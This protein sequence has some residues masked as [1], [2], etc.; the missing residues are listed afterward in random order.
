VRAGFPESSGVGIERPAADPIPFASPDSSLAVKTEQHSPSTPVQPTCRTKDESGFVVTFVSTTKYPL[1]AIEAEVDGTGEGPDSWH[2]SWVRFVDWKVPC[3]RLLQTLAVVCHM[4]SLAVAFACTFFFCGVPIFW[5]VVIPYL[6]HLAMSSR[7]TDG[8]LRGR[9]EWFRRC[10]MWR[11]FADYFPVR[12]YKTHELLPTRKYI[13][14]YHPHGIISHGAVAALATEGAGW[15]EK[16]PGITNSLCTL[17][18]NFRIPLLRDY[19]LAMGLQ[20][21][22]G[23]SIHNILTKGGLNGEGMGRSVTIVLGGARESLEAKPGRMNL[24]LSQ[25]KGFIRQAI[26][27]GADLVPVI[28][29]GENDLYNQAEQERHPWMHFF[30]NAMLKMVRFTLPALRGRGIFN[31]NF[32]TLPYR[33]PVHVVVGKPIPVVQKKEDAIR[34]D[35]VD[36]L[37]MEYVAEV[38]RLW[39]AYKDV[40]AKDRVAEMR[41]V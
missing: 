14:G 27:T 20:S 37:H 32:G 18:V 15:S 6:L 33:H 21:V 5:P 40:F 12:L 11:H 35:Y 17:D 38:V 9:S 25:R 28:G 26:R 2:R 24:C 8:T 31:D 13:L 4:S 16:F 41:I 10:A 34:D 1:L 7:S 39:D 22:S 3:R 30:Q 23:E 36:Q 29:F 19:A